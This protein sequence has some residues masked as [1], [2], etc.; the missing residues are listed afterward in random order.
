MFRYLRTPVVRKVLTFATL[1]VATQLAAQET[2]IG[3][4]LD[5]S[6]GC[7]EDVQ[8]AFDYETM[9]HGVDPEEAAA[10]AWAA[11]NQCVENR[12]S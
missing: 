8:V 5:C 11:Y 1:L 3:Q 12:C 6:F 2:D 9:V 7:H 4:A 10:V